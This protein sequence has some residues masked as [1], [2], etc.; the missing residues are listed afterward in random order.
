MR[1]LKLVGLNADGSRVVL[2]DDEGTQFSTPADEKLRAALRGDRARLGQ[3]EIEMQSAL[4]PRDI[5]A[6]IRA[7]DSPD[8]VAALAQVPV[9]RVMPYC[10]PVLA[11]RQHV[12]E[13]ARRSHVRRRGTES[14]QRG[15]ADVVAERLRGRGIDPSLAVW[16]AWRRDDGRWDVQASY[17]SGENQRSALFVFDLVG[18][19]SL[20]DDDEARW[21]T[22]EAQTTSHG[23]QP[24]DSGRGA[25]RR[26]SAV[27]DEGLV[28][29]PADEP[30]DTATDSLDGGLVDGLA[31][32]ATDDLTAVARAVQE[33]MP[34]DRPGGETHSSRAD[35]ATPETENQPGEGRADASHADPP[36]ADHAVRSSFLDEAFDRHL[37]ASPEPA[38]SQAER[39]A[40]APTEPTPTRKRGRG[41]RATMPSWD[42]IMFG[43]DD[44]PDT[45]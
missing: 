1:E 32:D 45:H 8:T 22:G 19:Y 18:R 26:L 20:P 43:K 23:P 29:L 31:D 12:A 3:L 15:L 16:D 13:L 33:G 11:E 30:T 28:G 6:R 24:R 44:A 27:S 4:R 17:L 36:D 35:E 5:Q 39:Q 14:N 2:V 40:D 41:R 42:E 34:G 7:G 25:G 9:E 10:L 21:L 38:G 37:P